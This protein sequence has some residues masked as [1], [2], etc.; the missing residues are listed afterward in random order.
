MSEEDHSESYCKFRW[1]ATWT[2]GST[3]AAQ[4]WHAGALGR[5]HSISVKET[6][7]LLSEKEGKTQT[8]LSGG[9]AEARASAG[10]V[11]SA[12]PRQPLLSSR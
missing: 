1:R 2:V 5:T 10:S 6:G 3:L 7:L 11:V 8:E 12:L 4:G 9:G